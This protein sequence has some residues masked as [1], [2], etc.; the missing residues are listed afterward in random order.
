MT[1]TVAAGLTFEFGKGMKAGVYVVKVEQNG[2]VDLVKLLK[3]E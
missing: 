1:R 3:L 2:K